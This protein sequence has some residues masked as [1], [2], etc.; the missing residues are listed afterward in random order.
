MTGADNRPR[1]TLESFK[2][3]RKGALL[4]FATVR[5][6][7]G[8]IVSDCAVCTSHG[9]VWASLPSKPIIGRDGQHVEE[10]GKKKYAPI[11]TWAD[12]PTAD[13]WSAAVVDLVREHHPDALDGGAA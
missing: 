11:L 7:N 2:P 9:K 10:G 8:L 13:K 6:P 3:L 4:G 1:M 5:L 12:R